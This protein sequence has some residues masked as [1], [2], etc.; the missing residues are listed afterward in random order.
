MNYQQEADALFEDQKR[1]W[2]LLGANWDKL[3]AARLKRINFDGFTIQ[4]QFNPKRITSSAAK[5]DKT[6]IENRKCFLCSE[7]R[8]HVQTQVGFGK[9]YEI[10][11]NPFPIFKEHFTIAKMDH[12]PQVIDPEFSSFLELS[13]ALLDLVVF[14]NAPACGASAPDHMHFQAGNRG[15]MPI[16]DEIGTI[17]KK[18]GELI[19]RST[20]LTATAVD[21]GLRRFIVLESSHK[22]PLEDTFSLISDYTR[23]LMNGEEPML[24]MLSYYRDRWQIMVFPRDRHRPWQFF[25]EGEKN[26]LLSPASVDMGGTL[27]TPLEKDFNKITR[28]D[29]MDIFSQITLSAPRFEG[30]INHIKSRTGS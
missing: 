25:E 20:D 6:S 9:E 30:L 29:I 19:V 14:Y 18:Y 15:F 12:T 1:S 27:I 11:C 5:I 24:N 8:P 22:E 3:E 13:R 4:V 21:D 23:D 28:E 16:E 26:I 17:L 7:N 10:L 2:P